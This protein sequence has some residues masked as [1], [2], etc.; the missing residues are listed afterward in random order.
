VIYRN[1]SW[2]VPSYVTNVRAAATALSILA[3]CTHPLAAQACERLQSAES[4]ALLEAFDRTSAVESVWDDYS[5]ANHPVVLIAQSSDTL[6]PSCSAIWRQGKPLQFV[7]APRGMRLSTP[8][9][10]LW[11]VDSI[12]PRADAGNKAIATALRR[13][14][15]ELEDA[16]RSAGETRAVIIPSPLY[17]DSI[18]NLGRALSAMKVKILPMLGQLAVHES[19]HLHSQ[20]PSWLDQPQRYRWPAWDRQP[21]RRALVAQC[22]GSAGPVAAKHKEELDALKR[23][24]RALWNAS[25]SQSRLTA[26]AAAKEFADA[27]SERYRLVDSVRIPS[28]P[29]EPVGCPRAEAIMELEEGAAQWIGYSTLVRAGIITAAEVGVASSE[30]FY[31]YGMLQL[32]V[33]EHLLGAEGVREVTRS[34]ARSTSPDSGNATIFANFRV[35]LRAASEAPSAEQGDAKVVSVAMRTNR[36]DAMKAFYT[37]AFGAKFRQVRTGTF[38]SGRFERQTM[39]SVADKVLRSAEASV[40]VCPPE[41]EVQRP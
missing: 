41:R 28:P 31:D 38:E 13:A 5:L 22:Y 40:L 36:H 39:G 23:A 4:Q 17:L 19:F 1:T 33:L 18:G 20:M 25:D 15:R 2:E 30:P 3:L 27:R 10:A 37:E 14:P 29:G 7:P 9:F 34:I 12:G 32:W 26:I 35:A 21:D 16:L 24:W 11:N 8:L 6:Q